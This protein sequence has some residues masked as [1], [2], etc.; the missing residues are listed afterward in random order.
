MMKIFLLVFFF[1]FGLLSCQDSRKPNIVFI[2]IDDLGWT[3]VGY[4]GST[5]YKT[6]NIDNLARQGMIFT[7]AY[8][9][10]ANC[11]PTRAC[12]MTGQYTP[13]HGVFTVANSDRGESHH[14]RLIPVENNMNVSLGKVS[15]AEALKPAGYVT[16]AI[17]KWHIGY[18]ARDHGFDVGFDRQ[19]I[20]YKRGHFSEGGEYLT[21]RLTD[22]AIKFISE[23]KNNPFFLRLAH[24]A[25]H[26]PI[27]AKESIIAQY[28]DEEGVGCHNNAVYAAMIQSVD[29]SVGRIYETLKELE[30]DENTILIF[31]SDNGGYG[32]ITCQRPLRGG[33]GMYYEGG[34]RVPMFIHWPDKVKPGSS[35]Q[36]PVIST[37]FYPTFLEISGVSQHEKDTLD[38]MSLFPLMEGREAIVHDKL[39]W[40]FPA[41]LESYEGLKEDSRDTLF[42]TRPVSV[43]RK[44]DW[45]LLQFHEEWVLDGGRDSISINNS[46]ELYNLAEDLGE[47]NNLVN[48]RIDKRDELLDDLLRWQSDINAPVPVQPNPEYLPEYRH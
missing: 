46:V 13:R 29:E 31:F 14:R 35:S 36:T 43:I 33:K 4:M 48:E 34:I 9:N 38:G 16:A 44:G 39:F 24:H 8:A 19:D 18:T 1:S 3:D 2:L 25:V 21:D 17:G 40:H 45:K 11:A 6:P 23:N 47:S 7:N 15:I 22:E 12:L 30:L 32:P 28:A 27:Q 41:Y 10:A 26:T 20:G 42:R 37:D 5:F